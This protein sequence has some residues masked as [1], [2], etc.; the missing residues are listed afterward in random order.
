[1]VS[2]AALTAALSSVA[3]ERQSAVGELQCAF[4]EVEEEEEEEEEEHQ[5]QL[6]QPQ[7]PLLQQRLSFAS[8]AAAN[9][10]GRGLGGAASASARALLAS[11]APLDTVSL[12][13]SGL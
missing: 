2:A 8:L 4:D 10:Q 5:Q 7:Q 1:M 9:A 12:H 11:Q 6:L 3:A 13:S